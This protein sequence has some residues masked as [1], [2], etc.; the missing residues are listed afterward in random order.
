MSGSC[1]SSV[2]SAI[3][4]SDEGS[5]LTP[6]PLRIR[7]R[8]RL[9]EDEC[10]KISS[11]LPPSAQPVSI[12][13]RRSSLSTP[14]LQRFSVDKHPV[15]AHKQRQSEAI[16]SK[17]EESSAA[18]SSLLLFPR[19]HAPNVVKP[20]PRLIDSWRMAEVSAAENV[21]NVMA[22]FRDFRAFTTNHVKS[23][24]EEPLPRSTTRSNLGPRG[25]A[26]TDGAINSGQ[27]NC[28]IKDLPKNTFIN[29]VKVGLSHKAQ[30][31]L[32]IK[33]DCTEG[34]RL[35]G[36]SRPC[37]DFEGLT[38]LVSPERSSF[39][40]QGTMM[41]SNNVRDCL[42]AFPTPPTTNSS[43]TSSVSFANLQARQK[44]LRELCKPQ[45]TA[46][47]GAELTVTPEV[48]HVCPDRGG[49]LLVA[50]DMKG[51]IDHVRNDSD[52]WSQHTG[53]DV[54]VIIDNS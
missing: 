12:P 49:T 5:D 4:R 41:S 23:T 14:S 18:E 40:T 3:I 24:N 27:S 22:K 20:A 33:S 28:P 37:S 30:P 19:H 39:S 31:N 47:M 17:A 11:A 32:A 10:T 29:R 46:I 16:H 48:D 25:R 38:T 8:G 1:R 36:L 13:I 7:K 42:A 51:A 26:V 43:P 50:V 45:D 53:L 44:R 34:K 52:S 35:S 54:V 9:G 6:K 15:C 21:T 2:D